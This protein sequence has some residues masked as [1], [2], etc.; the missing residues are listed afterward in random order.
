MGQYIFL[1]ESGDLGFNPKKQNSKYFIIT[2]LFAVDKSPIEKIVKKTH[3]KLMKK[4]KRLSGG[5]LHSVK[6]H[7]ITRKRLLSLLAEQACSIMVI[8][9]K[10]SKVYT[11]L[12]NEK[13]V[14]YNYVTNILLD[15]IMTKKL[16]NINKEIIM[17]AAKRE[18]NRFLNDNFKT[19]LQEQI[20]GK[21]R[22]S[23]KIEVKMPSEEK[24]LQAVDFASWAIFRKYERGDSLYYNLIKK[25]IVEENSLFK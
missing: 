1:D 15:R 13:H 17:I 8:Y 24:S 10:K 18:T 21:H 6:E 14:L 22:A 25:I 2:T 12:Q 20:G 23:I 16:L 11:K 19:Y 7:P 5:I 9:L 3:K 4:V